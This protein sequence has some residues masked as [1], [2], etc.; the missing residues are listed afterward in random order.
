MATIAENLQTLVNNKAAIKAALEK[1]EKNPSDVLGSYAE[2]IEELD[3]EEQ[4]SYVLTNA[5]GTQKVYAQLSSKEPVTL[6]AKANDIRLNTSAITNDGYT[7]G[8]K[9]I[10]AYFSMY[11]KKIV[12]ENEEATL[13]NHETDYKNLMVTIT[14]FNSSLDESVE[15][16]YASIDDSMY[17]A[18]S[19][20]KISDITVDLDTETIHFGVTVT[21][22]S[23][24]RYFVVR[25]EV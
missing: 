10:P 20:T 17:E 2:L 6:T 25:K 4:V 9:D 21:E 11:G 14:P 1:K 18:K 8:T 12:Y 5:D 22:L 19:T 3:N 15:V 24:L 16:T 7:E 23:V 13:T